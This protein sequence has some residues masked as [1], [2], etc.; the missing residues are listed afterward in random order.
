MTNVAEI[1]RSSLFWRWALI[2]AESL[3]ATFLIFVETIGGRENELTHS[4]VVGIFGVL[5]GISMIFLLFGSPFLISSQRLLAVI[6][7][8][9]GAAAFLAPMLFY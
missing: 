6:G 7:W 9:I 4:G 8:I 5:S 2:V 3:V 1:R